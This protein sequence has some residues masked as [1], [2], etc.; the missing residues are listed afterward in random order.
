MKIASLKSN[1]L[2]EEDISNCC[3]LSRK[4]QPAHGMRRDS[5]TSEMAC[6]AETGEMLR[7]AHP[8]GL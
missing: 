8:R 5:T 7:L 4:S 1:T 2:L 3:S 6:I